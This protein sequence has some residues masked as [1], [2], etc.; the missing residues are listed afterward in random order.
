MIWIIF[1]LCSSPVSTRFAR[2]L[3][4]PIVF[5]LYLM[6]IYPCF[7]LLCF[8]EV[9]I[10]RQSTHTQCLCLFICRIFSVC[11]FHLFIL[12]KK[13]LAFCARFYFRSAQSLIII[14]ALA[15]KISVSLV[16]RSCCFEIFYPAPSA[17]LSY[18]SLCLCYLCVYTLYTYINDVLLI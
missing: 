4:F 9:F 6:V 13:I 18:L 2:R 16:Y 11:L 8:A 7:S 3:L 1:F 12:I 17:R 10:R 5:R 14:V 15:A